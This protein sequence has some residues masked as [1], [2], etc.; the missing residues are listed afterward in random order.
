MCLSLFP[1]LSLSLSLSFFPSLSHP[2]SLFLPLSPDAL[3]HSLSL[4]NSFFRSGSTLLETMLDS[5]NAI[6]GL[7]EDSVFNSNLP[8]LR[9]EIVQATQSGGDIQTILE[10]HSGQHHFIFYE[11]I[12]HLICH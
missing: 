6:W 12:S 1:S 7:G 3:T 9:D 10:K 11:K 5:H 2:L 8:Y 4:P